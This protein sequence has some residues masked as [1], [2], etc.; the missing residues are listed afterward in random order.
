MKFKLLI[1]FLALLFSQ[2]ALAQT[3]RS[4]GDLNKV[5]Q[6]RSQII[7]V[8]SG[9]K[10]FFT[11][12][13]EAEG[14][15]LWVTDG[16]EGG[17]ALVK[18]IEPGP[19]SSQPL[20]FTAATFSGQPGA[21][22]LA[23]TSANGLELWK[24]NGTNVGTQLV[25]DINPG[26][27]N[28]VGSDL[29]S[30]G[31][32]SSP[33]DDFVLF[34]ANDGFHGTEPWYSSDGT[35]V[36]TNMM[37]DINP[38]IIGSNPSGTILIG[39]VSYAFS[40]TDSGDREL[41]TGLLGVGSP[42]KQNINLAAASNPTGLLALG[43]HILFAGNNGVSGV[44]AMSLS[45][46]VLADLTPGAGN[47]TIFNFSQFNSNTAFFSYLDITSSPVSASLYKTNG[48]AVGT[49][50]ITSLPCFAGG[51]FFGFPM[52]LSQSISPVINNRMVFACLN[53]ETSEIEPW[54]SDGTP[55][56]T[57]ILKDIFPGIQSSSVAAFFRGTD[58]L[59][60]P[61]NDAA[62]GMELWVTDGSSENTKILLDL[63]RGEASSLTSESIFT[64]LLYSSFN[65]QANSVLLST[66]VADRATVHFTDGTVENT[67]EI[68]D[69]SSEYNKSSD[70][71]DFIA[72]GDSVLFVASHTRKGRELFATKGRKKNTKL[73]KNI[74]RGGY[75]DPSGLEKSG[76]TRVLFEATTNKK[77]SEP[78]ITD[79]TAAG[80]KLLKNI[81]SGD[82]G[83]Y[84][85]FFKARKGKR[86]FFVASDSVN[87]RELWVT[88]G[89]RRSTKL[90]KDIAVGISDSNIDDMV[91]LGNKL[92][93]AANDGVNGDELWISD[94]TA[95]GTLLLLDINPGAANSSPNELTVL[96]D[97][98]FFSANSA[99]SGI[100]LWMSDGTPAGT[101]LVKDIVLGASGSGPDRLIVSGNLLFFKAST[102]VVGDELFR[103]D[104][105]FAGTFMVEDIYP[106]ADDSRPSDIVPFGDSSIIFSA[107]DGS[108][109]KELWIANGNLNSAQL[110]KDIFPGAD[111]SSSNSLY[112]VPGK[113]VVLFQATTAAAGDELWITDGTNAGTVLLA[114]LV[115]GAEGSDP[116]AFYAKG[117]KVYFSAIN[118]FNGYEPF[119][120]RLP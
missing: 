105:T 91:M 51:S 66:T 17:T 34:N 57:A 67:R 95:E 32:V 79:G 104:G 99:G 31:L 68:F 44:E 52:N 113:N 102:P 112:K 43:L 116:Y 18:D 87:G 92:I 82:S 49:S 42:S 30:I 1:S 70:P 84:P 75:S 73:I 62:H 93:F 56:G 48:T 90:V 88:K 120:V 80:T 114:D 119:V 46:G 5:K 12:S 71:E 54:F 109:G 24:T 28:G 101:S 15:E 23:R 72:L 76:R 55:A 9:N 21:Y 100:E 50:L 35:A 37:D 81:N 63:N 58:N 4:L 22:F 33:T 96:G 78:W 83:S 60:F 36:N 14:S 11:R 108:H 59:V 20:A 53:F 6:H 94:G 107:D 103:S 2:S 65:P 97:K 45:S 41:Y 38:G 3:V 106:G 7:S 26:P 16:T 69:D 25:K 110:L 13:T 98:V 89:T 77:G 10:I 111:S 115:P 27:A 86:N 39:G 64:T 85:S 19:E 117:P 29:F 47:S 40:A 74:N 118:G 61:A 8:Q